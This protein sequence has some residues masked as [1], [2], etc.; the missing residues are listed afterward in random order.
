MGS[1]ETL[2]IFFTICRPKFTTLSEHMRDCECH[3]HHCIL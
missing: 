1:V 3:H 2:V